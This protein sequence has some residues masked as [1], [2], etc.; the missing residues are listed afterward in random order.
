MASSRVTS[1]ITRLRVRRSS[2]SRPK[3]RGPMADGLVGADVDGE[4]GSGPAAGSGLP[5]LDGK[6]GNGSI[7]VVPHN[8]D[9]RANADATKYIVFVG[10]LEGDSVG[11]PSVATAA[12]AMQ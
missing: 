10:I 4:S 3:P 9:V 2:G 11:R 5:L 8:G 7:V 12:A 1:A 6:L